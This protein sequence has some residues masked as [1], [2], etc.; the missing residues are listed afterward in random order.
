LS[1]KEKQPS[2]LYRERWATA[3]EKKGRASIKEVASKEMCR[4]SKSGEGKGKDFGTREETTNR[5]PS[6]VW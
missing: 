4:R 1:K 2:L 5:K 6:T 3:E